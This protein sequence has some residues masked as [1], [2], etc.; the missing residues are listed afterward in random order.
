MTEFTANGVYQGDARN[1]ADYIAPNSIA[2]SVWSPPYHVGKSYEQD[3]SFIEWKHLL[4]RAI[5]GH[6]IVLQPGGFLAVNIADI[7]CFADD[8]DTSYTS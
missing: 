3:I 7:L 4:R 2:L 1:I 5:E 8:I 6:F